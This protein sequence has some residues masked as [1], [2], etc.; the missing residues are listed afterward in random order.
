MDLLKQ[1]AKEIK[2]KEEIAQVASVSSKDLEIGALIA[3]NYG[4]SW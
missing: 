2:S 1:S 4:Q 3:E